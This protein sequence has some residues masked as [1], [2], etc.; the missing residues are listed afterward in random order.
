MN[1]SWLRLRLAVALVSLATSSMPPLFM[2]EPASFAAITEQKRSS[3]KTS[4]RQQRDEESPTRPRTIAKT[5]FQHT[6]AGGPTIRVALL[7]DV[8]TVSLACASGLI[9]NR[10][11]D[12]SAIGKRTS[13]GSLRVE[14]RQQFDP[15]ASSERV[16]SAFRVVVSYS[17][18]SRVARNLADELKQRFF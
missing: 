6:S 12:G 3:E 10:G 11:P 17:H 5:D 13:D 4:S 15:V 14:L 18:D 1:S 9:V 8:T 2:C 7:T 16:A